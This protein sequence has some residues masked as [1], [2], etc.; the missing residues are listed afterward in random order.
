[1]QNTGMHDVKSG[2]KDISGQILLASAA[3]LTALCRRLK[4]AGSFGIDTEFI[5]ETSY[6]PILCLIQISMG[7]EVQLVVPMAL[8]DLSPLLQLVCD[9]TIQKICHAG[10]QDLAI[11]A[12]R[13]GARPANVADTQVLAGL[14]GL[15]YPL[16]YAKLV[17]Y[18]CAV[19]LAKAHTYSAWDRR[20]LK[21]AQHEFAIR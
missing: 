21:H 1:M 16:S 6:T 3:E 20:P 7:S 18:F 9:P 15:G 5:G 19:S 13:A 11:L 14:I 8:D 2:N 4:A 12:Q 17:E 10:E